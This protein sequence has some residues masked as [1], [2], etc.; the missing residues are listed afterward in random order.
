MRVFGATLWSDFDGENAR[1]L[2][3]APYFMVA[4]YE[5]IASL[6]PQDILASFKS[7]LAALKHASD[8]IKEDYKLVVLSHHAPSKQANALYH[9]HSRQKPNELDCYFASS[10]EEFLKQN[11]ITPALWCHGH[12]HVSAHYLI[13]SKTLAICNA[14]GY[15]SDR[16]TEHTG[17]KPILVEV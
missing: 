9:K 10:L 11:A 3:L 16:Y 1:A 2:E 5:H 8:T 13:N 7:S 17:Y 6:C 14:F 15:K 12:V 4:D